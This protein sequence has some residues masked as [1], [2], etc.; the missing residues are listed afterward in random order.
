RTQIGGHHCVPVLNRWFD[1]G[2]SELQR[3]V[4]HKR[5]KT[6]CKSVSFFENGLHILRARNIRLDEESVLRKVF[7]K[8]CAVYTDDAPAFFTEERDRCAA[9]SAC[10]AGN[11]CC[12][13]RHFHLWIYLACV[14]DHFI[15]EG[16]III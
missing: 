14:W 10:R 12:M 13:L 3:S 7:S 9:N 4:I 1:R 11:K 2:L 16:V 8:V 6:L 5:F 15:T